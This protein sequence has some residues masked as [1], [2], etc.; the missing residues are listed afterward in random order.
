[1]F[2][3][4]RSKVT[5]PGLLLAGIAA[6][7]LALVQFPPAIMADRYLVQAERE[8]AGGDPGA[9][10]EP[11]NR[12]VALQAEHGLE[13]PKAFWF[14]RAKTAHE[15]RLLDL[16]IESVVRYV[17]ITGQGGEHYVAALELYDAAELTMA[18]AAEL[19]RAAAAEPRRR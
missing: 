15:A 16:V 5:L 2:G 13:T 14:K 19:A 18:Q 7:E 9:A 11:L 1:M 12:I 8:L 17:E 6:S 4:M 3:I 10:V